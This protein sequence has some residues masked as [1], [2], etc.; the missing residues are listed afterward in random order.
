MLKVKKVFSA[1][2]GV[3]VSANVFMTIPFSAFAEN[4]TAKTYTY[5][6]YE[7]SYDVTNS[8][9]NTEVVSVTLS[10]TGDSAIE[11]WMLYF[12]PNGQVHDTVN[13]QEMQ[14]SI[15]ATYFKNSGYNSNIS[16]NS[17]VSFSYMVDDCEAVPDSFTLCQTRAEK[18]SGYQVSL[19][20]NQTWDDSFNGEIIIQNNTDKPIE[21]WEL[22]V[23]T[24]FTITEI[25]NS[26]AATVTELE[27][28][29]YMLKGTYTGTVY[30]NSSV[31]L[32]FI[33]VKSGDPVI[34]DYSLTEVVVDEGII[35]SADNHLTSSVKEILVGKNSNEVYFYLNS[36]ETNANITLYENDIPVAVFYDDG[37]YAAHGDDI[38]G[39][40]V[41]SVKYNV[42]TNIDTD[43]TNVYYAKSNNDSVS[44]EIS[45]DLIIPFTEQELSDIAYVDNAI[46]S[47]ISDSSYQSASIAERKDAMVDLLDELDLKDKI[48]EDS[49]TIDNENSILSFKYT[50]D[51]VGDIMLKEFA[52]GTDGIDSDTSAMVNVNNAVFSSTS[53]PLSQIN[54]A[55][56]NS[57]ENTPFR[58]D[59]YEE[60][61]SDWTDL[62]LN[63]YYD[64]VV[65]VN[66]LKTALLGK[67]VISL[68]G[69]GG[70]EVFCLNEEDEPATSLKDVEYQSDIITK[71]ISRV[72]YVD[73]GTT[74]WIHP[75]FFSYYYE[76]GSL[77]GSFIFGNSCSLMGHDDEINE[78]FAN[79]FLGA[80]A[81]GFV[82]YCN[83]VASTYSRNV[84]RSY[85]EALM[86]GVTSAEALDMAVLKHG[87]HCV[88]GAYPVLRGDP[89][90]IL[91]GE[92]IKNGNFEG[93]A[94]KSI[95]TP[96]SWKYTGDVRVLQKLGSISPYGSRM[97]FLSTG[98]GSKEESYI[99]GTQGSSMSQIVRVGSY[100]TLSFNYDVVSE[101]PDE[102]VGSIYNDKFEIQ[103]LDAN[104]NILS[105]EIIEAVNT[106]TWYPVNDINF[107]G[108]DD[109]AYHTGWATKTIDISDFQ[110]QIIQIRFLVY[111]VGDSIYD[112]AAVL[113]NIKLS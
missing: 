95:S 34:T 80:S 94:Q 23:D 82:G 38:Q 72:Y 46:A 1:F 58:S 4:D 62:G 83:N 78:S 14:T 7:I 108:G 29:S 61:V 106:S 33:G 6:G 79:A 47:V 55:I 45:V 96:L 74:Y 57:F 18:E 24:N 43:S 25:T 101:E 105:S 99:S 98:I 54:V 12:D 5:D 100:S 107:D 36:L 59:Y 27:P 8:W 31:S 111:D 26:W 28:Y 49:I 51:V 16:P 60:L 81:E 88:Y 91:I 92:D 35:A 104:D 86:T 87:E 90:A 11:N 112:T 89:N 70:V 30:A 48:V 44:N 97:A 50:R 3:A 109:T 65:S 77:D 93:Y 52:D 103:I 76:N 113:D 17:S 15:G 85:F 32:G 19:Q 102:W 67:Q 42:D 69:H 21:A 56:L 63:V 20:V 53:Q 68:S 13:V 66:D 73:G 110:N 40:G 2:V 75:S 84:M 71:R 22:T 37:N 9:G 10:N 64:D 41:Y 39:D